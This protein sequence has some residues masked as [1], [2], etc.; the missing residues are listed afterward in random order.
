MLVF[1]NRLTQWKLIILLDQRPFTVKRQPVIEEKPLFTFAHRLLSDVSSVTLIILQQLYIKL[2][3]TLELSVIQLDTGLKLCIYFLI[4]SPLIIVSFIQLL[5][6]LLLN[7]S[8]IGYLKFHLLIAF[9]GFQNRLMPVRHQQTLFNGH[10]INL[11]TPLF[12][13]SFAIF[14]QN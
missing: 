1:S 11:E 14:L 6:D 10:S 5:I 4:F 13:P 2:L 7:P 8:T 9:A 3:Y 12:P